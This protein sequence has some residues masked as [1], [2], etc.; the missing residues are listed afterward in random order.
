ML[1]QLA[2]GARVEHYETTRRCK[3]GRIIRVSARVL[4]IRDASGGIIGASDI[5]RDL[6]ERD[7][8]ERHIQEL[9]VQLAHVQR[10]TELGQ[11]VSTLVHEVNQPFTAIKNYLSACRRLAASGNQERVL[12]ALE[13]AE[14][15][16]KRASE[17]IRRIQDFVKKRDTQMRAE[18]LSLVIDEAVALVR[19]SQRG[20]VPTLTVQVDPARTASRD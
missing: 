11:V 3:D 9:Q 7:S 20:D 1:G 15:Q 19:S 16:T 10:L 17:I 4:P 14:D 2:R 13:Q 12:A 5:V 18:D 6:T 8:R